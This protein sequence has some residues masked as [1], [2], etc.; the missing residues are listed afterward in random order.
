[1][2]YFSAARNKSTF[3]K[4][5]GIVYLYREIVFLVIGNQKLL[6]FL[7]RTKKGRLGRLGRSFWTTQNKSSIFF[8]LVHTS[9]G[10]LG[11]LDDF[12]QIWIFALERNSGSGGVQ[13]VGQK[14]IWK[15]SSSR[16]IPI[17]I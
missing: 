14:E 7:P 8:R 10:R 11:R 2:S 16:P 17:C 9:P 3:V 12:F 1:M 4:N 15:K 5:R 6:W 13:F